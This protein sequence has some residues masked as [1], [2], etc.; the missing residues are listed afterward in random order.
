[1][2]RPPSCGCYTL[3]RCSERDPADQAVPLVMH[4]M[5]RKHRFHSNTG[6]RIP[7]TSTMAPDPAQTDRSGLLH[8]NLMNFPHPHSTNWLRSMS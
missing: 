3:L 1:M 4:L 8:L 7:H 5:H 6:T 2:P